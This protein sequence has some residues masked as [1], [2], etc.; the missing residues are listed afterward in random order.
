MSRNFRNLFWRYFNYGLYT[1]VEYRTVVEKALSQGGADALVAEL[2]RL[3]S[4]GSSW[5]AASL[6]YLSLLPQPN[7]RRDPERAL[8]HC[9]SAVREG[10]PYALFVVGWAQYLLTKSRRKSYRPMLEASKKR[11][12]PA[13]LAM[14]FFVWPEENVTMRFV[15]GALRAGHTAA[16]LLRAEYYCTGRFG[17]MKQAL[18]AILKLPARARYEIA[19]V[20]DP[21]SLNV[22]MF[23]I[24]DDLPAF[25][26]QGGKLMST[27]SEWERTDRSGDFRTT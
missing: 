16:L 9:S 19:R 13:T 5:A 2:E 3:A 4:L 17:L 22:L 27:S 6:G 25:R 20:Y 23:H 10:D 26:N 21:L 1:P 7:G 15:D 12:S 8:L 14:S 24:N 18:G 11:F